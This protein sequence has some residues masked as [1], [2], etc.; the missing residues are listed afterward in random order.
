MTVLALDVGGSTVRGA[1]ATANGEILGRLSTPTGDR[2]PG[3]RA[4]RRMAERMV[5]EADD[6]GLSVTAIGAGFPEYVDGE[7]RLASEEVLDWDRQ[8]SDLLA[9]LA[10]TVVVES[11]VRCGAA[12]ELHHPTRTPSSFLYVSLGTGLSHTMVCDGRLHRGARGEAIALGEV[13]V[14]AAVDTMAGETLER[15]CSGTGVARRYAEETGAVIADGARSV[16]APAAEGDTAAI[17]ILHSAGRA[18]GTALAQV[19]GLLDPEV[20]I[21]GGGLGVSPGLLHQALVSAYDE[22]TAR[23][24]GPPPLRTSTFGADAGLVGAAHLAWSGAR[25]EEETDEP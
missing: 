3:L 19:V 1:L 18:L 24:P 16:L 11:D 9:D 17:E 12:A 21:L 20:V 14:P 5:A 7:G 6:R 15:Y 22:G 2:D 4:T 23:R 13:T 8:P 25:P 10:P